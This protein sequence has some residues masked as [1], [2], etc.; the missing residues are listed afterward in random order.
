MAD[1]TTIKEFLATVKK[2][3]GDVSLSTPEGDM[4]NLKST[5]S[6]YLLESMH[7][8]LDFIRDGI[9]QIENRADYELLA[10]Y[11]EN[12]NKKASSEESEEA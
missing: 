9:L 3:K 7:Q 1:N 10:P 12:L 4:L 5:I 8:D 11:L 2:C 6:Q